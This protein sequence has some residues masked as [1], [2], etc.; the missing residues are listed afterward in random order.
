MMVKLEQL[1]IFFIA[2]LPS[3][4]S[5][6]P[7]TCDQ[8]CP[9]GQFPTVPYPFGF[10]SACTIQ[11]NCTSNGDVLIGD[12]SVQ[13]ITSSYLLVSLPAKCG[14]SIDTLMHLYSEHYAPL[15]T[16]GIVLD[17]CTEQQMRTCMISMTKLRTDPKIANC[18]GDQAGEG[19]VS[20]YSSDTS[21]TSMFLDYKNVTRTGCRFLFSGVA[22]SLD[23]QRVRLGWW[24]SGTC[25]CSVDAD[26]IKIVYP[27][28]GSNGHRCESRSEGDGHK[29]SSGSPSLKG[30]RNLL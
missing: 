8:S 25:N 23:V 14:R 11:L 9:G 1:L 27:V 15:S 10:N 18:S 20:C 13:Q 2:V 7:I 24:L 4:T 19:R 28:D 30:M 5:Q 12:F 21:T 16:N 29:T 22:F 17:N 3:A 26:C 6:N